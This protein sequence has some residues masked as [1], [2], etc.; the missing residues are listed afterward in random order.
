MMLTD[1]NE[2][3]RLTSQ[4]IKAAVVVHK[5]LGPGLLESVYQS[6]LFLELRGMEL[7]V[8]AELPVPIIYRGQVIGP[9]GFRLDLLV[10]DQVVVELKSVEKVQ[11]LHK[12]QLLTYL[13]L[14]D[15][16]LGL[17]INFN[18][19]L[20]KEGITRIINMPRDE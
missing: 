11:D 1:L 5:E 13:R 8:E 16:P 3:N 4:V 18:E 9:E 17:L 19:T 2:I 15:K 20:L 10:N 6:C 12:K 7:K 14:A